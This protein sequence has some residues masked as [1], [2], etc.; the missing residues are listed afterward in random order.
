[1]T[2]LCPFAKIKGL[3]TGPQL[4]QGASAQVPCPKVENKENF[5]YF[6]II[7]NLNPILLSGV[8]CVVE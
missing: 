6:L 2:P 8:A 5:G 4:G 3:G 1:M 7:R